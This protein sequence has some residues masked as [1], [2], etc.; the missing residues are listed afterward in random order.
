MRN[1]LLKVHLYLG[2]VAAIFLVILGLTGAVIAFEFDID[3]WMHRSLWYVKTGPRILP[4]EDLVRAVAGALCPGARG[5]HT[6]L[7][8]SPTWCR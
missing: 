4:E 8:R 3:H 6:D 5:G 2:L 7:A 1:V